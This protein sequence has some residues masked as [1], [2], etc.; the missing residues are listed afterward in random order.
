MLDRKLRFVGKCVHCGKAKNMHRA[1]TLDCPNGKRTPI[2]YKTF[3]PQQFTPED[4]EDGA[5]GVP[6]AHNQPDN[7]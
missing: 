2:G 3:G 4:G 6:A 1:F 5:A 7:R